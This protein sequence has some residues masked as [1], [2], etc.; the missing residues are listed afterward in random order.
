MH[1]KYCH[2]GLQLCYL[3]RKYVC[4]V[5]TSFCSCC[6]YKL[7]ASYMNHRIGPF[8]LIT[9]KLEFVQQELNYRVSQQELAM[10]K[11]ELDRLV[12]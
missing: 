11:I 12:I 10:L 9:V 1:Y 2:G 8:L 3:T 5:T 6:I 4:S 7:L